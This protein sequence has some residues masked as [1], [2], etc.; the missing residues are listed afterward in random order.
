[1][2]IFG[3]GHSQST[4]QVGLLPSVSINKKLPQEWSINMAV[5]SR[6]T[7]R[8]AEFGIPS[9]QDYNYVLTDF[10]VIAAK[11]IAPGQSVGVG[12]LMRLRGGSIITRSI[13]QYVVSKS[14]TGLRLSHRLRMDQTFAKGESNQYRLRYR[15]TA[16]L[17]LNGQVVD[18]QEFYFKLNNEYLQSISGGAYGVEIRVVPHIGF[19]FSDRQKFELGVDYRINSIIQRDKNSQFWLGMILYQSI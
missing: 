3:V 7:L 5:E 14:Y 8:D 2:L 4:Y 12:H 17:P 19:A 16:E 15:L 13:Q 9:E 11:R 6:Q 1:M 18:P 10:T